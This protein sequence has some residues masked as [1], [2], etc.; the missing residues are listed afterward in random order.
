MNMNFNLNFFGMRSQRQQH[1]FFVLLFILL[2]CTSTLLNNANNYSVFAFVVQPILSPTSMS[3]S[4]IRGANGGANGNGSS[5]TK[6]T[7]RR[8]LQFS[9]SSSA[10]RTAFYH[11][12]TTMDT[13]LSSS[14]LF[15]NSNTNTFHASSS[16][17]SSF[18]PLFHCPQL[19][20]LNRNTLLLHN[21]NH[22]DQRIRTANRAKNGIIDR[23]QD[24]PLSM[25]NGSMS[26]DNQT[27]RDDGENN[28][29]ALL[30]NLYKLTFARLWNTW[31]F[32]LLRSI[33]VKLFGGKK[34][35]EEDTNDNSS[36]Q[37]KETK[38]TKKFKPPLMDNSSEN[39]KV[40]IAEKYIQNVMD[41]VEKQEDDVRI[42]NIAAVS[43][44]DVVVTKHDSAI[45]EGEKQEK[46]AAVFA[47]VPV[48]TPEPIVETVNEA[49]FQVVT[50]DVTT[51]LR[52]SDTEVLT[53]ASAPIVADIEKETTTLT[54]ID[55]ATSQDE[56]IEDEE[57]KVETQEEEV[58]PEPERVKAK[59]LKP[60]I[61]DIEQIEKD[62]A[63]VVEQSSRA[64]YQ[65]K[66]ASDG[67]ETLSV[68]DSIEQIEKDLAIVEQSS[69]SNTQLKDEIDGGD[70]SSAPEPSES[71]HVTALLPSGNRW[72]I[73]APDVDLSATWKIVV[74]DEFKKAY[75][76]YLKNL[77][78][79]SIVRSI[80]VSIVEL[81]TEEI[82]QSD[83]GRSLCIKGKNLRGVW[84]RTLVAS[85][86]DYENDFDETLH[87]HTFVDLVT[88]DKERVK[89][90]AWWEDNGTVHR[91]YLRGGKKY[92]GGDF[93]SRRYLENDG[94][95]LICESTFH[96]K[97]EGTE[98]AVIKWT[99][100][101][102]G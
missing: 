93:E 70:T 3:T 99:F 60:I 16:S 81:T 86:S 101:R 4:Y 73:S 97:E 35:K 64:S 26:P 29:K 2:G 94:N 92:G 66:S 69:E 11:P 96:P 61:D 9:P 102:A 53:E 17:S 8:Q 24:L 50:P 22:H 30:Y 90:E 58:R 77:G 52:K 42:T 84:D 23:R 27:G 68:I 36:T 78:Q 10:T 72:A 71:K 19:L 5:S 44:A 41:R 31:F 47:P 57:E 33:K 62:I 39:E 80:A 34:E 63:V 12:S 82:T 65:M 87:E 88:A 83:K 13:S 43:T 67:G 7:C 6:S 48:P 21:H 37:E 51:P 15:M 40:L 75:D 45:E 89:A 74:S 76:L 49:K 14:G 38:E 55:A 79:P 54:D 18:S 85:G 46:D 32:R 98:P 59:E 100:N 25:L 56:K 95:T 28:L 91:S 20:N 1:Q